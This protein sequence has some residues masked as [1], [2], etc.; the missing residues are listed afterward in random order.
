MCF[1]REANNS[2]SP[3][4]DFSP[5]PHTVK[6]LKKLKFL[7]PHAREAGEWADPWRA[8]SR[9]S[10]GEGGGSGAEESGPLRT[11]TGNN[12]EKCSKERFRCRTCWKTANVWLKSAPAAFAPELMCDPPRGAVVAEKARSTCGPQAG[13]RVSLELPDIAMGCYLTWGVLLTWGASRNCVSAAVDSGCRRGAGS[14]RLRSAWRVLQGPPP[15]PAAV[16]DPTESP[17]AGAPSEILY[18]DVCAHQKNH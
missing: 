6:K 17:G 9:E 16:P 12:P 15:W 2:P 18:P 4:V 11:L 1:C 7:P 10:R 5:F 13:C 8:G 14:V 3:S